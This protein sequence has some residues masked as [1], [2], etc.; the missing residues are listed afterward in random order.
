M[1]CGADHVMD[2]ITECEHMSLDRNDLDLNQHHWVLSYRKELFT[3]W[4]DPS[5]DPVSTELIYKQIKDGFNK[6]D[7]QIPKVHQ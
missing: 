1:G 6:G 2:A 5:L 7:F 3:P 4:F